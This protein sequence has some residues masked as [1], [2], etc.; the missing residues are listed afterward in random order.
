MSAK[1]L[2]AAEKK[3]IAQLEQVLASC[4]SKRLGAYTVGDA[5]IYLYDKDVL[6][7][8]QQRTRRRALEVL[9]AAQEHEAAGSNLTILSMPFQVD[10]CAG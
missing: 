3:W 9:D 7:D 6:K 2:T 10:S 8:W 5:D 1:P 4:P